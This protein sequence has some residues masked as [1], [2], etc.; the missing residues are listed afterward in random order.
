MDL[1]VD[2]CLPDHLAP[3]PFTQ[4]LATPRESPPLWNTAVRRWWN[5]S[6]LSSFKRSWLWQL[7]I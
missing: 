4:F 6:Q 1:N 7:Q 3:S 2:F 5:P